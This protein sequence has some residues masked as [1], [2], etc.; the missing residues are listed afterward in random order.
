M[1]RE[2]AIISDSQKSELIN[3]TTVSSCPIKFKIVNKGA[4]MIRSDKLMQDSWV[5]F[6]LRSRY[7]NLENFIEKSNLVLT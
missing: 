5:C 7:F 1:G 2:T 4:F 3:V 6:F